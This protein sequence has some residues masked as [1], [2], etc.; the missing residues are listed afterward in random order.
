MCEENIPWDASRCVHASNTIH[1]K[2]S[3]TTRGAFKVPIVAVVS[4]ARPL[5][6]NLIMFLV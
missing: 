1:Y 5:L 6:C 4:Q 3:L 2:K